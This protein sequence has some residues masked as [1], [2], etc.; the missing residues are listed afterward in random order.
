[1]AEFGRFE[2]DADEQVCFPLHSHKF[3]KSER[4]WRGIFLRQNLSWSNEK[5]YGTESKRL[6]FEEMSV[7]E[8][9]KVLNA[10]DDGL[11]AH[12]AEKRL[13]IYGKNELEE[14]KPPSVRSG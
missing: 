14:K 13:S 1:M 8:T 12:E 4:G 3:A 10:G 11:P 7:F 5:K 2:K 6:H 9:R